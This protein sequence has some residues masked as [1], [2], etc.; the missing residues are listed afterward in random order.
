MSSMILVTGALGSGKTMYVVEQ[1][2]AIDKSNK[3]LEKQ[4]KHDEIRRIYSNIDGLKLTHFPL[5][6]DWR[7][8]PKNSVFAVDECHKIDIYKP[9]RK[10]L[11]DDERI[12]AMNEARHEGTIFYFITQSPKFLH[13]HVRG[14]CTQ[15]FHFHN[16]MGMKLATVF[17]WR[18]GNTTS[19]DSQS[20]KNIAES[21]FTFTYRQEIWD[22]YHSVQEG[23]EHTKK[24]KIPRKVIMWVAA[25]FI[26]LGFIAYMF[27]KPQTIGNLTGESFTSVASNTQKANN[28]LNDTMNK[29][30]GLDTRTDQQRREDFEKELQR[31]KYNVNNPYDH[32][33]INYQYSVK[34]LPQ[35]SG[36][37]QFDKTC[38]CYTQQATKLDV[39][40]KDCKRY[41]AGDKPFNPF[42]ES[43][44]QQQYQTQQQQY[45]VNQVEQLSREDIAKYQEA[46]RQ[47]LI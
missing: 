26:L 39:S 14:L 33:G 27:T 36:C 41:M 10:Q 35:L 3:E 6:D 22:L 24:M 44:Q 1:L 4:G 30:S 37:V 25:P 46:K 9:N 43:N 45:Q 15:H 5:P 2:A 13:Q 38:T 29:A 42:Y 12:I 20:S 23:A 19:P 21:E 32:S 28:S 18:H 31:V 8:C 16:P 17:M 40:I 11:H 7:T 34:Q 47:G